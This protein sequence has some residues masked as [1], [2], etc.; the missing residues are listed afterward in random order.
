MCSTG[1]LALPCKERY[2]YVLQ[3]AL[4]GGELHG[5]MNEALQ[6]L[7][8]FSLMLLARNQH[9]RTGFVLLATGGICN[10]HC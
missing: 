4:I 1:R 10:S 8:Q 3:V 5:I 9:N 6:P 7:E 2:S